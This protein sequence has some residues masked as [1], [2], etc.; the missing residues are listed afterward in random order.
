MWCVSSSSAIRQSSGTTPEPPPAPSTPEQP[1][2]S[3]SRLTPGKGKSSRKLSDT[4]KPRSLWATGTRGMA[5][6]ESLL[7]VAAQSC[8]EHDVRG[9]DRGLGSEGISNSA[10]RLEGAYT[11]HVGLDSV[12]TGSCRTSTEHGMEQSKE[13]QRQPQRQEEAILQHAAVNRQLPQQTTSADKPQQGTRQQQQQ[14]NYVGEAADMR[15]Q[16]QQWKP[17]RQ[18]QAKAQ[19]QQNGQEA[20]R[21]LSLGDARLLSF[22]DE[23]EEASKTTRHFWK[24]HS[25]DYL[26]MIWISLQAAEAKY[27]TKN[28]RYIR[29]ILQQQHGC[30]T[31]LEANSPRGTGWR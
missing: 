15:Q 12:Y 28:A 26:D 14:Q 8:R 7:I 5:Q 16:Q 1:T 10:G 25:V 2:R 21:H 13:H 20:T 6:D 17:G 9:S 18:Q 29:T 31:T 22:L 30:D 4:I 27:K 19:Q 11:P 23:A 24:D 3:I